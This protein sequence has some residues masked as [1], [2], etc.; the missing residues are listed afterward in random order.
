MST[1]NPS[2]PG[3][4]QHPGAGRQWPADAAYGAGGDNH[5]GGGGVNPEAVKAGHEPDAFAVKPIM[6]IPLAVV[7]TFVIAILV[8]AGT[9]AYFT[10]DDALRPGPFAHP[11]AVTRGEAPLN[12]QLERTERAGLRQNQQREVDQPRLEPLRRLESDG[13][14]FARPPLPT[15]NSPEIHWEEIRP[16]R[17]PALQK[18]GY[19]DAE[20]KYARIPITDAMR[21]AAGNKD[22]LPVQKNPSKPVGTDLRPSASNGGRGVQPP[23]PKEPPAEKKEPPKADPRPKKDTPAEKK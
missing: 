7:A 13:K 15:G 6:G 11:D 2:G 9:F 17:V 16:D 5:G 8:A 19:A 12:D 10:R 22:L 1:T 21:L 20:K 3:G 23:L 4:H 18:A 14:F